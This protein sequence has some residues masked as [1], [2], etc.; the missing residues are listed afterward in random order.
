MQQFKEAFQQIK[1][2]P[3]LFW[4]IVA[5]TLLNQ[6]GNMAFFF[7][8]LYATH[9]LG[10]TLPQSSI[11]FA[12]F[13]GSMLL[14]GLV[15]GFF[16][17]KLGTARIILWTLAANGI[18]LLFFPLIHSYLFC[19]LFTF[20]WGLSMGI[21]RPATQTLISLL[22]NPKYYQVIYSIYRLAL[23]LGLSIGPAVGGY[24]ATYY[25]FPLIFIVNGI[26]NLLAALIL[27][28]GLVN[29]PAFNTPVA[30]AE[31]NK[32]W[33]FKS[34][35]TDAALRLFLLASIPIFM[36]FFQ[37]ESPLSMYVSDYLHLPLSFYGLLFTINTLMI[38]SLEFSLNVLIMQWTYR[39]NFILGSL[40]LLVGFAGMYFANTQGQIIILVISWTMGEMIMFPAA[41]SYI[42]Q[43]STLS[44]R[45]KYISL[46]NTATN[47]SML[48]GPWSGTMIIATWGY[49]NLWLICGL[50]GL[51][52]VILFS[53]LKEP[54]A[55]KES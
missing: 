1:L 9:Y 17:D 54:E 7:L 22:A 21:Y 16:I 25:S 19:I 4:L 32:L 12:V 38:V 50:W 13:G 52:S 11:I 44:N 42:A 39:S 55:H 20:L 33:E 15:S 8:V 47:I 41:N 48:L 29:A 43:I 45:G 27:L 30:A 40:F 23:N 31:P 35:K 14:S 3:K 2:L 53:K 46:Y 5:A 6:L 49:K 28:P 51:I 10:F 18:I 37:F 36:V 24:L 34:L 26:A